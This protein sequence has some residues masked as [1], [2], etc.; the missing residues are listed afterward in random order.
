M[1]LVCAKR[2]RPRRYR[3]I[4][5]VELTDLDSAAQLKEVISDLNLFGCHVRTRE[6]WPNGTK[7]R[8]RITH[9]RETFAALAKVAYAQLT[10]MGIAFT[11]IDP[12]CESLLENWVASLRRHS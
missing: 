9:K 4:A 6:A 12:S 11:H 3:L 2:P 10:G 1:A 7:V 5:S 8:I